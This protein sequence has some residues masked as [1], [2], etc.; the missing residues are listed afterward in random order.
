[1]AWIHERHNGLE[2]AVAQVD[3]LQRAHLLLPDERAVVL[4]VLCCGAS[5]RPGP[6]VQHLEKNERDRSGVD[7]AICCEGAVLV[8]LDVEDAP[9][10]LEISQENG[11]TVGRD[12]RALSCVNRLRLP[13]L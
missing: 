11:P 12:E 9:V 4:R 6:I 3:E 10:E 5:A 1:M 13:R 7:L 8:G 2:P